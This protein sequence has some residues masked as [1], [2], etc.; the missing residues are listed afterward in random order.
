MAHRIWKHVMPMSGEFTLDL[1]QG[2]RL[3]TVQRQY[4]NPVMWVAADPTVPRASRRFFAAMTGQDLPDDVINY[5]GTAVL[6]DGSYV[7]H[8]LELVPKSDGEDVA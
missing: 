8:I 2:T 5:V 1:P 6:M 3:L 7:V 4:N